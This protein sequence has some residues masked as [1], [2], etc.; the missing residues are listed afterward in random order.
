MPRNQSANALL[1]RRSFLQAGASLGLAL[2]SLLVRAEALRAAS[3]VSET[4]RRPIRS[5]ILIYFYGGPSHLDMWDMK[6]S[7][8]K[9]VRGER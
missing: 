8:P 3:A 7:A 4:T 2:P 5:C 6:P 9:E 1:G